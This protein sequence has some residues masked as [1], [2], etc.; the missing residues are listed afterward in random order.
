MQA[1]LNKKNP[2]FVHVSLPPS[3]FPVSVDYQTW[4]VAGAV[5]KAGG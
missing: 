2:V 4:T 3:F 5:P 1:S